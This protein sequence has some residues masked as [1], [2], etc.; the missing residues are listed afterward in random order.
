[1]RSTMSAQA[2]K[3][4]TSTQEIQT[5][6][7]FRLLNENGTAQI[8]C[9]SIAPEPRVADQL[10]NSPAPVTLPRQLYWSSITNNAAVFLPGSYQMPAQ[11][12]DVEDQTSGVP[13]PLH[14]QIDPP[15][16]QRLW[17]RALALCSIVVAAWTLYYRRFAQ[18]LAAE[19]LR[20]RIA[21]DLHD[22]LG[23]SLSQI[24]VLSAVAHQH[25][26]NEDRD[27]DAES[28]LGRIGELAREAALALTDIVWSLD[29]Q[30]DSVQDLVA[31]LRLFGNDLFSTCRI[32]F[33]VQA[34]EHLDKVRLPLSV[35]REILLLLKEA[36]HNVAR[37]AQAQHVTLMVRITRTM[38]QIGIIDDGRGFDPTVPSAGHGLASM[39]R[40][41]AQAGGSLV[42]E[43]A[44]GSGTQVQLRIPLGRK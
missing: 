13:V 11:A 7:Q 6:S 40:R 2:L 39:R 38:L 1:M 20:L 18:L 33:G 16:R 8:T 43:R 37:H 36:M 34:P 41:A 21:E 14:F 3:I 44:P 35:R 27:F 31:R 24:A 25:V 12:I 17:F 23:S 30:W 9:N 26:R 22:D 10:Q 29:P 28:A 5:A 32:S 4:I 42:I 15:L 19:R